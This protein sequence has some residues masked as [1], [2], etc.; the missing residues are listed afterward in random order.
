MLTACE[1]ASRRV[2]CKHTTQRGMSSRP[3]ASCRTTSPLQSLSLSFPSAPHQPSCP[4]CRS[5]KQATA[6]DLSGIH[7]RQGNFVQ[8]AAV[9]NAPLNAYRHEP[10]VCDPFI[11]LCSIRQLRGAGAELLQEGY[12][13][14][15]PR[16]QLSLW[17]QSHVSRL[18]AGV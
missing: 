2:F 12:V 8:H 9:G 17:S 15:A 5:S 1:P 18:P 16:G 13:R 4:G 11:Q 3:P 10:K 14:F 6:G 7:C